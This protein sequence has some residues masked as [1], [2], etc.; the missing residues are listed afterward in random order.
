SSASDL[1]A[2]QTGLNFDGGGDYIQTNYSGVT[3]S[4]ARTV[5]AWIR[6]TKDSNPGAGGQ[7]VIVDWGSLTNGMRFTFNILWNNALRIEIAGGG[8]NGV[9]PVNDGEWHHVAV[10]Y[11][12]AATTKFSLYVD[13]V[14]DASGNVTS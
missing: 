14:L 4:G 8:L 10:V 3:G 1:Q 9:T 13:G 5:E 6:T 12:P 2:Q 11:N 7:S